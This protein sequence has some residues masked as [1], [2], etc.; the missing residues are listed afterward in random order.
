MHPIL[1]VQPGLARLAPRGKRDSGHPRALAS[2]WEK[3]DGGEGACRQMLY[4]ESFKSGV[5]N[6]VHD[7]VCATYCK[8]SSQG[9]HRPSKGSILSCQT[10]YE[11][12]TSEIHQVPHTIATMHIIAKLPRLGR[13][14]SRLQLSRAHYSTISL[15]EAQESGPNVKTG[16]PGPVSQACA[17]DLGQVFDTR[18]LNMMV[19]YDR[20]QGNYIVDADGNRLLDV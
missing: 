20:S 8:A 13:H 5:I 6:H 4:A 15:Q 12:G 18:S 17:A 11:D 9:N 14:A 7:C 3:N 19:D 10:K 1:N 2:P 16:I